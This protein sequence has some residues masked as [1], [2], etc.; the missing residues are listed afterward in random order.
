MPPGKL[1]TGTVHEVHPGQDGLLRVVTLKTQSEY[2][3]R[4]LNKITG[5]QEQQQPETKKRRKRN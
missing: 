1:A 4:P 3:E 5:T 2:M